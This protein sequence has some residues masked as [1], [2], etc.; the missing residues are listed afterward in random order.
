MKKLKIKFSPAILTICL[1]CAV[2]LLGCSAENKSE[3][4]FWWNAQITTAT[5]G[6]LL[7]IV[8]IGSYIG[9][10]FSR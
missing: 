1:L 9:C 4:S 6:E 3:F 10:S 2:L 8:I 5:K 7:L